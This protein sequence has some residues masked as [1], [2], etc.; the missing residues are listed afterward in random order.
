MFIVKEI[1]SH[2]INA[3]PKSAYLDVQVRS[4]FI[5]PQNLKKAR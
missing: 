5:A 2:P 4:A 1:N 3:S